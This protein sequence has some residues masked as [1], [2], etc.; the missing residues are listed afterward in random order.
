MN[1]QLLIISALI[2]TLIMSATILYNQGFFNKA[3]GTVSQPQTALP[4]PSNA[5]ST[6]TQSQTQNGQPSPTPFTL[7]TIPVPSSKPSINFGGGGGEFGD[8]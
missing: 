6:F 1:K 5:P 2:L 4:L 3:A 8:D 7:Q